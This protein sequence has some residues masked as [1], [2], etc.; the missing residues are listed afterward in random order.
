MGVIHPNFN[1]G[2][3]LADLKS[4]LEQ[5]LDFVNEGKNSERCAADLKKFKYI[6]VPKV[7]WD[8]TSKVCVIQ[9][10]L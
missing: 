4:S 1:F 9:Q 6:Y 2:W 5:E 10:I 3:V 7:F 8:L